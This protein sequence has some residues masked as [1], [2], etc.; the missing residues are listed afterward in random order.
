MP[1]Y[2][3]EIKQ[4]LKMLFDHFGSSK[5]SEKDF[6]MGTSM[7]LR[8]FSPKDAQ[9]FYE[10][11]LDR[12]L[13]SVDSE[14][15]SLQFDNSSVN[16]PLDFI[17]SDRVLQPSKPDGA[18]A[19]ASLLMILVDEVI[20]KSELSKKDVIS[21]INRKKEKLGIDIEVAAMLVASAHGID[22]TGYSG[23]VEKEITA[24][25]APS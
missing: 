20:K 14:G 21:R 8:W 1:G 10:S 24:R 4:S 22:I 9:K 25:Y 17:P 11:A 5:I 16:V 23:R 15:V 3:Q 6:I 18:S 7:D 19:E 2:T 12:G 13:I